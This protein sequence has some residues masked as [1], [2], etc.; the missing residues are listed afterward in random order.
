MFATIARHRCRRPLPFRPCIESLEDRTIPSVTLVSLNADGTAAANQGVNSGAGLTSASADGQVVAFSSRSTDLVA[1]QSDAN[2]TPDVFVRDLQAGVTTLVSHNTAGPNVAANA[3]SN[4]PVLSGNGRFVAFQSA[5]TDL[6]SG[7]TDNNGPN[8]ADVYLFDRQT[9]SVSLVSH[10]AGS[11]TGGSNSNSSVVA[12]SANGQFIL[13]ESTATNLVSGFVDNNA[14]GADLFLYNTA[15]NT[16][17]L[18]SHAAGSATAGGNGGVGDVVMSADGRFVA[19]SSTATNL[20]SGFTDGNG[21]GRDI[22]LFDG[23]TGATVLVSHSILSTA[24]GGNGDSAGPALSANGA[25]VAFGSQATDLVGGFNDHNG[26][27]NND[28]YLYNVAAGTLSLASVSTASGNNGGNGGSLGPTLNADGSVVTFGSL[29]TD[30]VAGISDTNGA[31]NVFVRSGGQTSLVSVNSSGMATGNAGAAPEAV[32]PDGRLVAFTSAATDLVSGVKDSNGTNDVFV[33]DLSTG[34]TRVISVVPAG[35]QTGNDFSSHPLFGGNGRVFFD[36]NAG[37][38]S[39]LDNNNKPDLFALDVLPPSVPPPPPPAPLAA[40]VSPPVLLA[41]LVKQKRK[42]LVFVLDA[43]TGAL[44]R[45]LGP[46]SGKVQVQLQDV[47]GDGANDVLVLGK[48]SKPLASFV[49]PNTGF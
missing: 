14:T 33:R 34:S 3:V 32:S 25:I 45:V 47:N 44:L 8:Q 16:A 43:A 24:Q 37:D 28:I 21:T 6:L 18:V 27:S 36:S 38:L 19:Y 23:Q 30:L 7:F 15:T 46:F 5:A 35:N 22:F 10:A 13:L 40:P 2:L 29:A 42:T 4:F 12:I 20:V 31:E 41:F 49:N 39:P 11:A 26:T 1:G 9:G 17:S 48:K